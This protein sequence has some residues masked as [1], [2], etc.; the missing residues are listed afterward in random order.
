MVTKA[1]ICFLVCAAL[2]YLGLQKCK[3]QKVRPLLQTYAQAHFDATAAQKPV[4]LWDIHGVILQGS[5]G[6][7]LQGWWQCDKKREILGN[8]SLS[9]SKDIIAGLWRVMTTGATGDE[10]RAIARAHNNHALASLIVDIANDQSIVP[11]VASLIMDL[12]RHG[13]RQHIG[14]NIGESIFADLCT[15]PV[16][17]STFNNS[18]FDFEASQVVTYDASNPGS[19]LKKPDLAFYRTYLAKNNLA[20]D[21]VIFIDDNYQNVIAAQQVGMYALYFKNAHQLRTD[22]EQLLGLAQHAQSQAQLSLEA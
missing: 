18:I 22:L 13:Y 17:Q 2:S 20:A 10:F 1:S 11:D 12:N 3:K 16:M 5:H 21:Q 9:M 7:V 19:V 15:R 8:S 14:S 4:I 6:R